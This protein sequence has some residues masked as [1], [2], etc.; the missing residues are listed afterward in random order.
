VN[1]FPCTLNDGIVDVLGNE[2]PMAEQPDTGGPPRPHRPPG[3]DVRTH[4][5][6]L[7]SRER[8]EGIPAI[9]R[10]VFPFG[11]AIRVELAVEGYDM[12]VQA[13]IP[14]AFFE[15]GEIAVNAGLFVRAT[16]ARVFP[17]V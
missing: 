6:E 8:L 13:E 14:R 12:P 5:I 2:F 17:Q 1:S 10:A 16:N 11:G 4:E 9:V 15:A 3:A 7:L